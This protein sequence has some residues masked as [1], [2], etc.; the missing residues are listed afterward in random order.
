M[1]FY[2]CSVKKADLWTKMGSKMDSHKLY[3]GKIFVSVVLHISYDDQT[4]DS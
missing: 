3:N 2:G 1:G 4:E